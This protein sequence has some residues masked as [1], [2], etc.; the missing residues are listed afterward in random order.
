L[1]P[2][3]VD[4]FVLGDHARE[5]IDA[6]DGAGSI[7]GR[8]P[9]GALVRTPA[10]MRGGVAATM[11]RTVAR[12][13]PADW[14]P[15]ETVV[16]AYHAIQWPVAEALLD[17]GL[18]SELWYC[19]W[20]RYESAQDAGRAH[21][22]LDEWHEAMAAR[23]SLIF[24]VSEKLAQLERDA[25]REAIVVGLSAD[26]F[27]DTPVEPGGRGAELIRAELERRGLPDALGVAAAAGSVLD[28]PTPAA[29]TDG[30]EEQTAAAPVA[31]ASSA[32]RGDAATVS[33]AAGPIAVSLGHLGYRTDW[34]WLR[35]AIER[36]PDLQVLLVG[37]WH[38]TEVGS[39]PDFKWLRA[40]PQ[41][42]WLGPLDD[43]DAAAVIAE[44][45]IGLIPFL[46]D[47]FNDAGLPTRILKYAR[48]GR[49][50]ISPPLAGARTWSEVVTF[51]DGPSDLAS[52]LRD[53]AGARFTP[54]ADTR[55]WAL[56]QTAAKMN[57]PLHERLRG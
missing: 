32:G 40:D 48:L 55:T 6:S 17:R 44:A 33:A 18:A 29:T 38:E 3:S 24:A 41:A 47:D 54:D 30:A 15:D 16:V 11:A 57:A 14:S 5:L 52:A 25:G 4:D 12:S 46:V 21:Q 50:T 43:E 35:G 45:D 51:V 20:D 34:S 10:A 1:L 56:E 37:E 9:Y 36:M 31:P 27:P 7:P 8:V 2:R 23:S 39:D 42:V 26:Q 22:V 13:I 49:R 28:H 53:A 19:R